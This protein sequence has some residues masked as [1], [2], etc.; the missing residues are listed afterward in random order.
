MRR[1]IFQEWFFVFWIISSDLID[2]VIYFSFAV[3]GSPIR[4]FKNLESM[5]IPYPNQ[6]PMRIY[7]SL[8]NSDVDWATRGGLV[9]TNWSEAPFTVSYLNF[10]DDK[11]CIWSNGTSSCN[12]TT[13]WLEEG[14]DSASLERLR[15]V[16]N[17][18]MIYNYCNDLER[19]PQGLPPECDIY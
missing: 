4:V 13:S 18:Y 12:S 15:W 9:K 6:Q 14:F 1:E 19:F 5:G 10:D 11:S 2:S 3:D 16:Q 7:C 8:C 17:N